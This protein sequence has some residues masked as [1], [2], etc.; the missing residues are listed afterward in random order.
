MKHYIVTLASIACTAAV[1]G[2]I[3]KD[4]QR[5]LENQPEQLEDVIGIKKVKVSN[6]NMYYYKFVRGSV[7]PVQLQDP[8][9]VAVE[10]HPVLEHPVVSKDIQRYEPVIT[11]NSK[12]DEIGS[13]VEKKELDHVYGPSS[14]L[15]DDAVA[16]AWA[17]S[18]AAE[19]R[20]KEHR[21]YMEKLRKLRLEKA[22]AKDL[23]GAINDN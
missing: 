12:P 6:T 5:K 14:P 11:K 8:S 4:I 15:R 3:F 9:P 16:A 19:N 23:D 13:K 2:N 18:R 21:K 1:H 20:L 17:K 22:A 10:G 7:P